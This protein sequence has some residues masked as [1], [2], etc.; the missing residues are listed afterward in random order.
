MSALLVSPGAKRRWAARASAQVSRAQHHRKAEADLRPDSLI[1]TWSSPPHAE[2]PTVACPG[3]CWSGFLVSSQ[4][5]APQPLRA[6]WCQCSVTHSVKRCFLG[7]RLSFLCCAHCFLTCHWT[8]PI[9]AC[10][11]LLYIPL[12]TIYTHWSDRHSSFSRLN[13]PR[14]LKLSVYVRQSSPLLIFVALHIMKWDHTSL[15]PHLPCTREPGYHRRKMTVF[16][17]RTL[18]AL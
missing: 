12:L 13:G 10:L 15:S 18:T 4:M 6:I 14:I 16:W 7:F 8:L 5:E 3:L 11:H 1:L 2:S 17:L 9:R